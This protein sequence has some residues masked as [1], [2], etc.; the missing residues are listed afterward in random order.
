MNY[1]IDG[2]HF[3]S[4]GNNFNS[5]GSLV[6]YSNFD[7]NEDLTNK[8]KFELLSEVEGAMN[9]YYT[10]MKKL[11]NR[12]INSSL[13]KSGLPTSRN[14]MN[15]IIHNLVLINQCLLSYILFY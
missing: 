6:N 14:I 7:E 9:D 11:K 5:G 3:N 15:K 12:K 8:N 13:N 10:R 2:N 4:G 1:N